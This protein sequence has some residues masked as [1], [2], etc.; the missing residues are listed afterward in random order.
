MRRTMRVMLTDS[1]DTVRK[2]Q[3]VM[4][5]SGVPVGYLSATDRRNGYGKLMYFNIIADTA[6]YEKAKKACNDEG[7]G[8]YLCDDMEVACR[9]DCSNEFFDT[10]KGLAN[11]ARE[12]HWAQVG[13]DREV[14]DFVKSVDSPEDLRVIRD[15][16]GGYFSEREI[17]FFDSRI[18]ILEGKQEQVNEEMASNFRSLHCKVKDL[19][20]RAGM[21]VEQFACYFDIPLRT[22]KGWEKSGCCPHYLYALM[23]EKLRMKEL[24]TGRKEEK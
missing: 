10:V 3:S 15:Y 7:I 17:S 22:V 5:K 13:G 8:I 23:E 12:R 6:E 24:L 9:L 19:R 4:E 20:E 2:F 1:G 11:R 14:L 21:T 16:F 18:D